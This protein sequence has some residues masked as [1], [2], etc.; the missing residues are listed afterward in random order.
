MMSFLKI[1]ILITNYFITRVRIS[2]IFKCEQTFE[3]LRKQNDSNIHLEVN[4]Q[5]FCP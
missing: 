1:W 2:L 4:N 3:L 5:L